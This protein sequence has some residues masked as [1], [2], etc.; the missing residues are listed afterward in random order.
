MKTLVILFSVLVSMTSLAQF[1]VEGRLYSPGACN[2]T[3]STLGDFRI[4]YQASNL[5]AMKAVTF[6]TGFHN[7]WGDHNWS[8]VQSVEAVKLSD[9]QFVGTLNAVTVA[10]RGDYTFNALEFVVQIENV[11]GTKMWYRPSDINS[12]FK[13]KFPVQMSCDR[14]EFLNLDIE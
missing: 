8:A 9:T 12:F 7:S 3:Y 2:Y 6:I 13:A 11:D 14:G 5:K 4:T 10:E 1:K